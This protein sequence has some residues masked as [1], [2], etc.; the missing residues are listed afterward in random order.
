MN[1]LQTISGFGSHSGGTSTCT[2]DLITAMYKVGCPVDLLTLS[3]PDLMRKGE[4]WIKAL[5]NDAVT[6]YG[7]SRNIGR[8]LRQSGYDLY[9]T[10]GLWMHCNHVTCATARK[11]RKPYIITPHGMLYPAA[12]H[13]SYWKKW[14]LIQMYFRKDINLAD[15]LHVTCKAEMEHVRT[16]G[17]KGPIAIIPNP[18][19]LPDYIEEVASQ[20]PIFLGCNRLRK[21]GFLGRLH[22][23]KKVENLLY[24]VAMLPH[25]Q[26]CELVIMGKGDDNYEQF[27]RNEV[28]RLGLTN[29]TFSGFVSGRE[30]Y[31]QLTQ[32]SCLFVPS[33][34]ENF[35]MIVTEALSVGT[36]VM[37]SLGTP[38]EELNTI[39][40]GWWIDR[41]PEDIAQVMQ[42]V[43]EMP[44]ADLLAMDERGRQLVNEKYAAP[45]VAR[46]MQ[47]LYVWMLNGGEKPEFVYE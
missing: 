46:M 9:H 6:P 17:Y 34:F 42:Q 26:E 25:P 28:R 1:I 32:L 12:L 22:P 29:V 47:Q 30:K 10:N 39:G 11:K 18:A 5:P 24:G 3:S 14:P 37:A 19:N 33:D 27:L 43:I 20:K 35:G 44:V 38:W 4:S 13:R 16:F 31:E 2:Y 8:F 40:C 23:R 15:C 36:P 41:K 45:Q 7:Y 21:L